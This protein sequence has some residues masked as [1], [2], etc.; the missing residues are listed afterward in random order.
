MP[1]WTIRDQEGSVALLDTAGNPAIVD[2]SGEYFLRLIHAIAEARLPGVE[3]FEIVN[4][5]TKPMPGLNDTTIVLL[6]GDERWLLPVEAEPAR[7]ILKCFGVYPPAL[8]SAG[9]D[10]AG[11]I[12]LLQ[13]LRARLRWQITATKF[14][15]ARTRRLLDKTILIPVGYSSQRPLPLIP[16]EQRTHRIFFAGSLDN[17]KAGG[18][19]YAFLAN[20]PKRQS[21]LAMLDALR[22]LEAEL[23]A[24]SVRTW[25]T[26]DYKT[27]LAAGWKHYFGQVMQAQICLCPRG[28]RLETSRIHET[29]RYG[30]IVISEALPDEWYLRGS[31]AIVLSRWDELLRT[32]K[33]LLADPARMN[34]LHRRSLDWWHSVTS[35]AAVAE[36]V[37]R[38]MKDLPNSKMRGRAVDV[39]VVPASME[40]T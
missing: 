4:D 20:Y 23:P 9:F 7:A 13:N 38:R 11:F 8:A 25:T 10:R 31:P 19:A 1:A 40:T 33:E 22:R 17:H 18:D 35:P 36:H 39:P 14:G 3:R 21:R 28:S 27:S 26:E 12:D 2:D 24:G 32:V 16:F 30:C 6:R 37:V 29:M 5:S 34:E 15:R